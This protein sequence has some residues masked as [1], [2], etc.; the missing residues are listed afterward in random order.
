MKIQALDIQVGE[1]IAAYCNQKMQTCTVKQVLELSHDSIT[2]LVSVSSHYRKSVSLVV[3][4]RR[5][6]LVEMVC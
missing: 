4:F 2:L 5:N 6:A 1:H 3:R